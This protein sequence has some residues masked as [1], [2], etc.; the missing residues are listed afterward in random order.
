MFDPPVLPKQK[1]DPGLSPW[2]WVN[3]GLAAHTSTVQHRSHSAPEEVTL[4]GTQPRLRCEGIT[5][6]ENQITMFLPTLWYFSQEN[7]GQAASQNI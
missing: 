2:A 4:V 3:P 1:S 5:G 7:L 6:Q